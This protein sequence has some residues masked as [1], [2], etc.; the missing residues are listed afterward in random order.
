MYDLLN[1][2]PPYKGLAV[3]TYMLSVTPVGTIPVYSN[4]DHAD[5]Y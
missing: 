4:G 2:Q 3:K 5:I 1:R